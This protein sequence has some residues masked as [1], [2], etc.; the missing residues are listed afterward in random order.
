MSAGAPP[1]PRKRDPTVLR[2]WVYGPLSTRLVRR[3]PPAV[4]PTH[5]TLLSLAVGAVGAAGLA[6]GPGR[7]TWAGLALLHLAYLLDCA[8]GDLARLRGVT[9]AFGRRLD[10]VFD[11]VRNAAMFA[12]LALGLHLLTD[13]DRVLI[14]ALFA[15][16]NYG[17]YHLATA[18]QPVYWRSARSQAE[19]RQKALAL[20]GRYRLGQA[21]T[22]LWLVTALAALRYEWL[23]VILAGWAVLGAPYWA[24]R[25]YRLWRAEGGPGHVHP[26]HEGSD[27]VN[28]G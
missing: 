26:F 4:A 8:N 1:V 13:D 25:L 14:L 27:E 10:R 5:L 11:V 3:L 2:A 17:I 24:L 7:W 19:R 22:T 15:V 20:I 16:M 28:G 12:G 6:Q 23:W 9:S 21:D 18:A